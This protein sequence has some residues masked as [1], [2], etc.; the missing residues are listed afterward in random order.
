MVLQPAL[1]PNFLPQAVRVAL[2]HQQPLPLD[3]WHTLPATPEALLQTDKDLAPQGRRQLLVQ[4]QI[5]ITAQLGAGLAEKWALL[6]LGAM[7]ETGLVTQQD[8][9][10]EQ[11]MYH[12]QPESLVARLPQW[13]AA[14][15][16]GLLELLQEEQVELDTLAAEAEAVAAAVPLA[17]REATAE[18]DI[19]W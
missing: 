17:A 12:K 8:L 4:Q 19:A 10:L 3:D 5:H 16:E 9:E 6:A 2:Q 14:V 1:E 18:M 13:E 11:F 7:V 15:A